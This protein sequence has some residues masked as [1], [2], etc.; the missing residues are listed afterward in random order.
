VERDHP[1]RH[2]ALSSERALL[3]LADH[4]HPGPVSTARHRFASPR[5]LKDLR[6]LAAA[7]M[8]VP[9]RSPGAPP[10]RGCTNLS[11]IPLIHD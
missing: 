9:A 7:A 3:L 11:D 4:G 8:T 1:N 6:P 2:P 5:R 10:T